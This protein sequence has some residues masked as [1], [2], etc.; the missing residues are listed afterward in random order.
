[1][2]RLIAH[3]LSSLEPGPAVAYV[4]AMAPGGEAERAPEAIRKATLTLVLT[5]IEGS[6]RLWETQA[7]RMH[8]ALARHDE[9]VVAAVEREGGTVVQSKAEG[10][11]TFSV[12]DSPTHAVAA[13]LELQRTLADER[14][15]IDAPLRVRIGIHTGEVE[16]RRGDFYGVEISRCA[17]LRASAHGGQTLLSG[18]TA[19][20]VGGALPPEAYL[21][22]LGQHRLKDLERA[23]RVY[24]LCHPALPEM[25]PPLATLS[26]LRH[27]LPAQLSPF[28]GRH[29]EAAA[30]RA[31]LAKARLVT[32]TG[33]GGCG[34]TR[35]ALQ[36][37]G[38]LMDDFRDGVWLVELG[39]LSDGRLV[40]QAVAQTLGV[41]EQAGRPLDDTL[42]DDLADRQ[43]LVVLDNCEHLVKACAQLARTLLVGCPG[44]RILATSRQRLAVAGEAAW[45]VPSLDV[46][47]AEPSPAVDD[48]HRHSSVALFVERAA[49]HRPGFALTKDNA[50]DVASICR[51]LE[52]IPLAIE[53]AAARINVLTPGQILE[54]LDDRFRLL[55]SAGGG[56]ERHE[57][58][59]TAVDWSYDLLTPDERRVFNRM[60]VFVGGCTIEAAE[61]V[62]EDTGAQSV[63]DRLAGLVDKSLV[64]GDMRQG[65][66][67]YHMLET[68]RQYAT[69]KLEESGE[70]GTA[71]RKLLDWCV[72]LVRRAEPELTGPD[73]TLW[74]DR[75]DAEHSNIRASLSWGID[76]REA[77]EAVT[78]LTGSLWRYWLERGPV[79]E[80]RLWLGRALAM[81]A[82]ISAGDRAKALR[83]AGTLAMWQSDL[84]AARG[85]H[86]ESVGISRSMGDDLGTAASLSHL[87]IVAWRKGETAEAK[88]LLQESLEIRR[89]RGD[90]PGE[91]TSLGNLGLVMQ[92]EGDFGAAR[93][94][95][96]QSLEI[97]RELGDRQG[98]AGS[99][100]YLGE[101]AREAGDL[102]RA[103]TLH[104]DGLTRQRELPQRE[105]PMA[106]EGMAGLAAARARYV[107][108]ARLFGA[109]EALRR[110]IGLPVPPN[111][112][113]GYRRD[114]DVV[115]AALGE[116]ELERLRSEGREMTL[117]A[118]ISYALSPEGD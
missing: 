29:Q 51:S 107:R 68:I 112:E 8:E 100:S 11:S 14:W 106:L 5:D 36:I 98:I 83:A 109:A 88:R 76:Q 71:R 70:A 10:D 45:L 103:E 40:P 81:S 1:V 72:E 90:R 7:D 114:L 56:L 50:R 54:R 41:R 113:P 60:S 34:K 24:Q 87:G 9:L 111:A 73:Q 17:R 4:L 59:R 101:L 6:T 27:N 44:L 62:A 13:A 77:Q 18:A 64:V 42:L 61:A 93:G 47:P 12:F 108:A 15:T 63:L 39:R 97:D 91:S 30:V 35:L 57:T 23:E 96:E 38:E 82:G 89:R 74:F 67:R 33:T 16:V 25:F 95:L 2:S 3:G 48:L 26:A 102:D 84:P 78:R 75:I 32:L 65:T 43:L 55:T 28:I 104:R 110:A 94:L 49:R 86:E 80:G 46:P 31:L 19:A 20:E 37:A 58:L 69:E 118:A 115:R 22:D 85:Y 117:D 66:V 52:G 99:L 105:A 116:D 53:L 79:R 21:K 92:A